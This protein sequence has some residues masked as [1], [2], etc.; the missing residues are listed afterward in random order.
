MNG[1]PVTLTLI[2]SALAWVLS[3]R[4][5]NV[6]AVESNSGM[7][8]WVLPKFGASGRPRRTSISA[9][10]TK[11][12]IGLAGRVDNQLITPSRNWPTPCS[13]AVT[14]SVVAG[15][16]TGR[17]LAAGAHH[18][19]GSGSGEAISAMSPGAEV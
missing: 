2:P 14:D 18:H 4:T 8:I 3:T 10:A 19:W 1:L 15:A 13:A 17:S 5:P 9:P 16:R 7:M 12:E 11:S 6:D